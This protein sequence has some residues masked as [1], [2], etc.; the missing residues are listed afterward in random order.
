MALT[1]QSPSKLGLIVVFSYNAYLCG[2]SDC[3][4][5]AVRCLLLFVDDL[6]WDRFKSRWLL[7]RE[8]L[9]EDREEELL[10]GV[11]VMLRAAALDRIG[12]MKGKVRLLRSL[13]TF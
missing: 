7:L 1:S 11:T 2:H 9:Q 13:D 4:P 12:S 8:E 10:F 3:S 5:D 6:R